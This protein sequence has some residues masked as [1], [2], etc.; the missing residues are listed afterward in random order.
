MGGFEPWA[1]GGAAESPTFAGQR[2]ALG[3]ASRK[4]IMTMLLSLRMTYRA[5]IC[6]LAALGSVWAQEPGVRVTP[7]MLQERIAT[8]RESTELDEDTR[9]RLVDLYRQALSNLEARRADEKAAEEFRLA[10]RTAPREAEQ[11]RAAIDRRRASDPTADLQGV[12]SSSSQRLNRWLDEET[13]NL[14][15]A[16]AKLAILEATIETAGRRPAD[17]RG[18]IVEARSAMDDLASRLGHRPVPDE[19]PQLAE[20]ARWAAETRLY[21][22]QSEILMLDQELLSHSDRLE[23]MHAEWDDA[24]LGIGRIRQRV[25]ILQEAVIARR[26]EEAE[27]AMTEARAAL[28]GAFSGEL[29]WAKLANANMA[30]VELLPEQLAELDRLAARERSLPRISRIENAHRNARRRLELE[31][32]WAPV[33]L[34]ILAERR[35]L[36]GAGEYETE[37]R[38]VSRSIATVSLRLSEAEEERRALADL[39]TYLDERIAAGTETPDPAFRGEMEHLGL[40]RR[41]LL[42]L[43]IANDQ[44]LQRRL[45]DLDDVLYRLA[46]GMTAYDDFLARRLLWVRST[47]A[48]DAAAL[49]RLPEEVA[50]YLE[51]GP[52]LDLG[53]ATAR[54]LVRAP[55]YLL[56]ALLAIAL[57]WRRGRVRASLVESGRNV[58]RV[59]EDGLGSTVKALVLTLVLAAPVPLLLLAIGGA[60]S[61][62]DETAPFPLAVG[63]L[64]PQVAH[65]IALPIVVRNLFLPGGVA[66]R[67]F[68]WDERALARARQHLAW[69]IVVVFP[70][71]LVL[72][73]SLAQDPLAS[74]GGTLAFLCAVTILIGLIALIVGI[75]H[76]TRGAARQFL[77]ARSVAAQQRWRY[78]G[79]PLAVLVPAALI[80][81]A[82]LGYSY[83]TQELTRRLFLTIWSLAAVWL[84]SA[85]ARRWLL[86]T[87]RRLAYQKSRAARDAVL[88]RRAGA[89]AEATV[90]G[91][92]GEPETDLVA[93][94]DDSRKLLAAIVLLAAAL[95][96][97]RV[98]G[99]MI[100]ALGV[101]EEVELWTR[102]A[103]V[104]G[105]HPAVPVTL[106]DL[107]LAAVIGIG[108]YISARNAPSLLDIILLKKGGVS[109]GGRYAIATLTRYAITAVTVLA[110]LHELGASAAQLGWAAAALGVGI[111]FG[112]QEIVANFICGLILLFERPVR[113]G[114]VVTLGDTSGVVSKI[115][116]RAT[117]IRDWEQKELIVPNKALIT[118]NLLNWTL[119][120][121]VTRLIIKVG[122]A[123]GSDVERAMTLMREAADENP[124]VLSQPEPSVHFEQFG[125]SSLNLA[126]RVHVS[127]V[128]DRLPVLTALHKA[129]DRA[130]RAAGIV[131]AFPQ[132]DVHVFSQDPQAGK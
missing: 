60:L 69:F 28:R 39:E 23:V 79:F 128:G 120:D 77:A 44:A 74:T 52:W 29:Q 88:A 82:W 84:G 71:Y 92:V 61:T 38:R 93:L 118:G 81:L 20:A 56:I 127:D 112:L 4:A 62:G 58:G 103:P 9:T 6:C 97:A 76:P 26:R 59:R 2:R 130:F 17:A 89:G 5:G 43:A 101:L 65:W 19:S 66:Q 96:L 25:D 48:I 50:D 53:R 15:A 117:T 57:V 3:P 75:A 73:T 125:E 31:D 45:Y 122:V 123:Y 63:A 124:L 131:I 30:L 106:L 8:V 91:D 95:V 115:R 113:I 102:S 12:S 11:I 37:R 35:Q 70:V 67:H 46:R 51:P 105:T 32:P 64:L 114:D 33:G 21:A 80:V 83:T 111:G 10:R 107:L 72:K 24:A 13:A 78:L 16:E 132:R 87:S 129:I 36:P 110:V 98:W 54:R 104:E 121:Q 47:A 7:E 55:I 108:G 18:R 100:P 90:E 27:Q 94:G 1:G 119:S 85:L 86:V 49:A 68:G 109:A 42:D 116:I 126:L 40:T 22:L 99:E 14:T 34:T 41:S